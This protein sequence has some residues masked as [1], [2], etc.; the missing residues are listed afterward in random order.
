MS[1]EPQ[2]A[3]V[4]SAP[5]AATPPAPDLPKY[6]PTR[7]LIGSGVALVVIALVVYVMAKGFGND[8]H[9]VPFMLSGAKAPNF[10]VKR[11][12]TGEMVTLAQFAGKPVVVNFWAT[13]CGPCKQE[14]PVLDWAAKRYGDKVQFIGIVFEDTEQNTKSYLEQVGQAYLQL[15]DAKSTVAVDYGVAGVPET[16]FITRD[17]V[18]LGK[19]A[20]PIDP[21][22]MQGKLA[23]L[24]EEPAAP[25]PEKPK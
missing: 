25:A 10:S 1:A 17:G 24:L 3:P 5:P 7:F 8:P 19:Y 14:Q 13:W 4:P 20:M 15:Y 6:N 23:K 16:Y 22:T 11:L 18:I 21:E 12:D 2:S 9:E